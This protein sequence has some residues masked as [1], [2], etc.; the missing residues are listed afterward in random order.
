MKVMT[1]ERF[2]ELA[3]FL[4]W[5][6]FDIAESIEDLGGLREL[7]IEVLGREPKG[8]PLK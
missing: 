3:E 1:E 7:F 5:R 4:H 6:E 2:K 8:L